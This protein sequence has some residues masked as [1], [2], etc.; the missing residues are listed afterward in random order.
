MNTAAMSRAG[1]HFTF[2]TTGPWVVL[3]HSLATDHTFWEP[4]IDALVNAGWRVLAY[5]TRGHGASGCPPGPW[6]LDDMA[7]DALELLDEVGIDQAHFVGL[8]MGGMI[9]QHLALRAPQRLASLTLSCT[10][11]RYPPE[12]R[13]VWA[14]RI[15][16][17][18]QRGMQAVVD[19]T[20]ERWF[21][22]PY[23]AAHP[24]LIARIGQMIRRTPVEGYAGCAN[25]IV[26]LNTTDRLSAIACPVLVI[27]GESDV[28]T[29]PAMHDMIEAAIP[30]AHRAR[31]TG[32]H[33]CNIESA[34][35]YN[36]ALL[37]FLNGL[38]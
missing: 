20:L 18:R 23:R 34:T 14:E 1:A 28:G 27:S 6:S 16:L 24:G 7:G 26:E 10:S 22:E 38:R 13:S 5:D 19:G 35:S 9:G 15:A 25:A 21:T 3:S 29:P 4:Q 2:G 31:L 12:A 17:V 33:L 37:D 30:H 11:S 36:K 8:S 32:A